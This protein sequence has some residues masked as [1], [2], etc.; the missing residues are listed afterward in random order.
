MAKTIALLV[1]PLVLAACGGGSGTTI[2]PGPGTTIG[3]PAASPASPH[4]GPAAPE[5]AGGTGTQPSAPTKIAARPLPAVPVNDEKGPADFVDGKHVV[6]GG[7][8]LDY[9]QCEINGAA[10]K[11]NPGGLAASNQDALPTWALYRVSGLTDGVPLSLNGELLPDGYA[12]SYRIA[13]ADYS[14]DEWVW[15]GPITF[16]EYQF[17][18]SGNHQ[19]VSDEGNLHFMI[20]CDGTNSAVH[21]RS[22]VVISD[23][24]GAVNQPGPVYLLYGNVI[25]A[26]STDTTDADSSSVDGS[27]YGGQKTPQVRLLDPETEDIASAEYDDGVSTT[28]PLAGVALQLLNSAGAV[29]QAALTDANGH[30]ELSAVGPGDYQL[31]AQLAG[32]SFQPAVQHFNLPAERD[33]ADAAQQLGFLALPAGAN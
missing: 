22:T 25:Y 23:G 3:P 1:L 14:T 21:Y 20:V 18:L 15:L 32:W 8:P 30:Y 5:N 29:Q 11:L 33:E 24:A 6:L 12:M 17:D 19:Y 16:P 10:V 2:G 13:V 31:V 27:L 7:R 9:S 4:S 28:Q 26:A